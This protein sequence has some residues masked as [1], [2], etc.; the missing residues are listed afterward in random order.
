[1]LHLTF[2]YLVNG[3]DIF[4]LF[5]IFDKIQYNGNKKKQINRI[6]LVG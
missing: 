6:W 4:N 2:Y 3:S 1:M 5:L